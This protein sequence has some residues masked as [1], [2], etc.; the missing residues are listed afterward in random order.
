M[1]NL[2]YNRLTNVFIVQPFVGNDVDNTTF[3]ILNDAV[4]AT[5]LVFPMSVVELSVYE[6]ELPF[7]TVNTCPALAF[8]PEANV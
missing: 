2:V 3:P 5:V 6:I 8:E 1:F 7:H 4:N